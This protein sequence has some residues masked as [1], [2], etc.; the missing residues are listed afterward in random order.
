LQESGINVI[1]EKQA[2]NHRIHGNNWLVEFNDGIDANIIPAENG[3]L[4]VSFARQI[5]LETARKIA[6]LYF[7][8]PLTF[9]VTMHEVYLGEN[10]SEF[11]RQTGVTRQAIS[12]AIQTEKREKYRREI[13]TLKKQNSAFNKMTA[14]ELKIYQ[15]CGED[16]ILSISNVAKQAGVSRQ[17]VYRVLHRLSE[18]YG[19][20]VTLDSKRRKKI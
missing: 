16:G 12:K 2:E 7:T 20:K 6:E 17:T 1:K 3:T 14:A 4:S 8:S 9:D 13:A 19:L 5:Q 18:K 10:H 15:L 11:A